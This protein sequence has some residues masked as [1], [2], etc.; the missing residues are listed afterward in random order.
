MNEELKQNKID[1]LASAAK[2]IVGIA[3]FVG[4]L[5]AEIVDN[6]IPNQKI[7]RLTKFVVELEER[8]SHFEKDFIRDQIKD[9]NFTDLLE[10]GLRQAS[11]AISDDRKR[12]IASII[13]NGLKQDEINYNEAKYLMQLLEEL[14]DIEI[15]WLRYFLVN[16]IGGDE[17]FRE[18][19]KAILDRVVVYIGADQA[20]ID[21]GAIQNSYKEHLIRLKL[22]QPNYS[23]DNKTGQPEYDNITKT[24]KI[25]YYSITSLGKLVLRY[26]GLLIADE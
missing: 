11:K 23:F 21:K 5:L 2:S 18:K 15:I 9:E 3:P 19:H 24:Q 25:S 10:E 12:Y 16:T 20:T 22:I 7:D 1:V 4:P 13:E 17:E 26:I 6:V 8:F 14:N